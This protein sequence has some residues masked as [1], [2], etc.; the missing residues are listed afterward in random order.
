M[1][2]KVAEQD[3]DLLAEYN[4]FMLQKAIRRLRVARQQR[5]RRDR[6]TLAERLEQSRRRRK[7]KRRMVVWIVLG[8]IACL[9]AGALLMALYLRRLGIV[10]WIQ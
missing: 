2:V 8:A 9:L 6:R 4:V 10:V 7:M 5:D 1:A 3:M